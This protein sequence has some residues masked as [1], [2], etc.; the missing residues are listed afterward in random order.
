MSESDVT[1][2]ESTDVEPTQLDRVK[3][4]ADIVGLKYHHK[5]G[6]EKLTEQLNA[7][8]AA[9]G[10]PA[11]VMPT[12]VAAVASSVVTPASA[13]NNSELLQAKRLKAHKLVR[14]RISCM[15]SNKKEWTGEIFAVGNRFLGNQKKYIPF[16]NAEGWHVPQ[17]ILTK[18][19][20]QR[21]QIFVDR[22]N[23]RGEKIKVG[24]L[25]PEYAVEILPDLSEGQM[26]ELARKQAL[27]HSID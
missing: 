19:Q 10:A 27:S 8:L 9:A 4:R 3:A 12:P 13:M 15:N 24:K 5:V 11:P 21:M 20:N 25:V 22:R 7:L 2:T 18:I 1:Q 23:E 6:L 17:I 26:N 14:V 16:D